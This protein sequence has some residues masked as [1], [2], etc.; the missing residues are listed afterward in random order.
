MYNKNYNGHEFT[1]SYDDIQ[2]HTIF[3]CMKCKKIFSYEIYL[4][5]IEKYIE[6]NGFSWELIKLTCNE[7]IIKNI[8]E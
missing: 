1:M 3:S 5:N 2:Q 4:I 7:T 8:I 6:W